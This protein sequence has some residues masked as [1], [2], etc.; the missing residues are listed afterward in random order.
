MAE[1]KFRVLIGLSYPK[2]KKIWDRLV[3]GENLPFSKRGEIVDRKAGTIV[4]MPLHVIQCF[5]DMKAIEEYKP[6]KKGADNGS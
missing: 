6:V 4:T 2:D 3:G 5:L 1:K